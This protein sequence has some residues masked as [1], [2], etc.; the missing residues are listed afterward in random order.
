MSWQHDGNRNKRGVFRAR[1]LPN[2]TLG[3][4]LKAN[5]I[6]L[7]CSWKI[8]SFIMTAKLAISGKRNLCGFQVRV[9][10]SPGNQS[11]RYWFLYCDW[12]ITIR[13]GWLSSGNCEK[14][15]RDAR[16]RNVIT[17]LPAIANTS[18]STDNNFHRN[19]K[20]LINQLLT[21]RV[22]PL[23]KA[24]T[25]SLQY[26]YSILSRGNKGTNYIN[27]RGVFDLAGADGDNNARI[28]CDNVSKIPRTKMTVKLWFKC[29]SW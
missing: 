2:P 26:V 4:R 25:T 24:A 20:V 8:T 5:H 23:A 12:Q 27:L 6:W 10:Q 3:W 9:I 29:A 18:T 15:R 14:L 13:R 7:L 16:V 11:I 21:H 19:D 28:V 17:T 1:K 22:V